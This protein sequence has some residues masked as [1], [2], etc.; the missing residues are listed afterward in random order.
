MDEATV[1]VHYHG[2]HQAYCDK[3]NA[4]YTRLDELGHKSLAR[5]PV[6]QLLR[7]LETVPEELRTTI[8][9]SGN[10]I[11]MNFLYWHHV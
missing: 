9:N 11:C 1:R 3:L 10:S 8:R 2:H 6:E 4:A 5:A 7:E